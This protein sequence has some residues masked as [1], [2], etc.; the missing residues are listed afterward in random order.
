MD[1]SHVELQTLLSPSPRS[2][3][4]AGTAEVRVPPGAE[5]SFRDPR[6]VVL[7]SAFRRPPAPSD[8][9]PCPAAEAAVATVLSAAHHTVSH[10]TRASTPPGPLPRHGSHSRPGGALA[11]VH[12]LL[13]DRRGRALPGCRCCWAALLGRRLAFRVSPDVEKHVGC[14]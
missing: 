13:V 8:A 6:V 3:R 9:S 2:G 4:L 11:E 7:S 1:L 10:T 14:L 5:S 12:P